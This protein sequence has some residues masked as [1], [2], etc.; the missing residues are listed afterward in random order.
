MSE[1]HVW[2]IQLLD[3]K[4]AKAWSGVPFA[5]LPS[6]LQW[7][8]SQPHQIRVRVATVQLR[9]EALVKAKAE[10]QEESKNSPEAW[11]LGRL[12]ESVKSH[13]IRLSKAKASLARL[14][15]RLLKGGL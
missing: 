2:A 3:P 1:D 10:L 5:E 11:R 15:R 8:L 9:E 14:R 7:A 13:E 6:N 4:G 12:R